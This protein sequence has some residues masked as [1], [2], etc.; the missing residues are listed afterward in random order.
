MAWIKRKADLGSMINKAKQIFAFV[1]ISLSCIIVVNAQDEN[2]SEAYRR[3]L[4]AQNALGANFLSTAQNRIADARELILDS[5]SACQT[6]ETV[7]ASLQI[8]SETDDLVV[9]QAMLTTAEELL[10]LCLDEVPVLGANSGR[11][12]DANDEDDILSFG[13]TTEENYPLNL[14]WFPDETVELTEDCLGSYLAGTQMSIYQQN[15]CFC[16]QTHQL[17][18]SY[19][20]PFPS[21]R[22][23]EISC[24]I[25][26]VDRLG[27]NL[28]CEIGRQSVRVGFKF[29]SEYNSQVLCFR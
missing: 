13:H 26:E 7:A 24:T 16:D 5:R 3:I 8:A 20:N 22:R 28:I 12:D 10:A 25:G 21:V 27:Y 14:D 15:L 17:L 23:S 1:T 6:A 18:S 19:R 2:L 29:K 9:I 11:E 4:Q